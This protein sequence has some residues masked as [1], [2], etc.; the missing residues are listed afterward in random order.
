[1]QDLNKIKQ[2]KVID[3]AGQLMCLAIP[4][5]FSIVTMSAEYIFFAYFSV[6]GWQLLSCLYNLSKKSKACIDTGRSMYNTLLK[7]TSLVV[8]SGFL[9]F[10]IAP[11][12]VGLLMIILV[13]LLFLSPFMAIQYAVITYNEYNN[14]VK[15]I[16]AKSHE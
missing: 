4:L 9:L 2:E 5:V 6:G 8:G 15:L 10:W 1:M 7:I 3:L 16:K 12:T 11:D 13:A 14:I